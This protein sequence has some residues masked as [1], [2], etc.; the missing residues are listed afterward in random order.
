MEAG[1]IKIHRKIRDHWIWE[2]SN[3]LKWWLD[4][5]MLVNH[6]PSKTLINN[7]L[8]TIESGMH[9]TSEGKLSKRWKVNRK[10]VTAFLDLLESDSMI[11]IEKSRRN[12]T[13]IK[14]C[15][16]ENHQ[17]FFIGNDEPDWV[18]EGATDNASG[19]S[20]AEE[21]TQVSFEVTTTNARPSQMHEKG[22]KRAQGTFDVFWAAYP[23]KASKGDARKAWK[24]IQ[25]SSELL[26]KMLN[27]LER[28]KT[29]ANWKKNGGQYIPY[30]ATWLRAECWEDEIA[31]VQTRQVNDIRRET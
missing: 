16:Y 18:S 13:T 5:I 6:K 19:Y 29:C 20:D 27:A 1:W 21:Y 28:A 25:P 30:P 31:T 26:T 23:K 11:T 12:G 8:T 17:D 7:K 24:Q 14:L 4:L 22:A 9:H 10:T 15:N 3:Y 2:N